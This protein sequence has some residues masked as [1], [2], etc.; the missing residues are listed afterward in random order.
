M[1]LRKSLNFRKL[2]LILC[3]L[4]ATIYIIYGLTPVEASEYSI[5]ATLS[6]PEINL[7]SDV[8]KLKLQ[9]HTLNTPD[10][11][12]GSFSRADNKTLLIGHATTIFGSLINLDIGA[13]IMY[14]NKYYTVT[15]KELLSKSEINMDDLLTANDSDTLVLMTCAGELYDNGDASHRI[16]VTAKVL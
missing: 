3:A 13:E 5:D 16:I 8:T 10:D 14:S 15:K 4:V 11:I 2:G 1:K 7:H 9:N 12:V 6:I